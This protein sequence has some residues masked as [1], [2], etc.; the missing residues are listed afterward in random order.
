MVLEAIGDR[1]AHVSGTYTQNAVATF[2]EL[3]PSKDVKHVDRVSMQFVNTGSNLHFV[4]VYGSCRRLVGTMAGTDWT[5]I[6]DTITVSGNTSSL[7]SISTT[8]LYYFG[9]TASGTNTETL[10]YDA[11]VQTL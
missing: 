3:I 9:A 6:G 5:Q 4:K 8:G 1:F 10:E 7:K 11:I 2:K